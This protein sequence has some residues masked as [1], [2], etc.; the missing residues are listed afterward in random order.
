MNRC[1]LTVMTRTGA[2]RAVRVLG[3]AGIS[4]TVVSVDPSLTKN[5]CG[6][7][8][9]LDCSKAENAKKTLS[10]NGITVGDVLVGGI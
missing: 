8:V 1:T 2:S 4:S 9:K 10:G 6:Y 5:G 3:K 7:G